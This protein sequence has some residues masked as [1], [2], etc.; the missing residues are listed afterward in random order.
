MAYNQNN[1]GVTNFSAHGRSRQPKNV[2]SGR[3]GEEAKTLAS[4]A[5]DAARNVDGSYST[6]NQRFLHLLLDTT[7]S[8]A[9]RTITV[10]GYSDALG[11]WAPLTDIKGNA[12]TIAANNTSSYQIYEVNGVDRV[13][14]VGNGAAALAAGDFFFAATST[15]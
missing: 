11:R 10:F 7:T 8:E 4:I 12:I 5:G 14:F 2:N 13:A 3:A 15:F 9:N 1:R 6:E